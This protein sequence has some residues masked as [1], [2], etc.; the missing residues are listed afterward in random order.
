MKPFELLF[1]PYDK[2]PE[3]LQGMVTYRPAGTGTSQ[4]VM[5]FELRKDYQKFETTGCNG[6]LSERNYQTIVN[7]LKT[8]GDFYFE[9]R[10]F[11]LD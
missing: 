7:K 1:D 5:K 2:K 10:V 11:W 6:N 4:V 8:I 9:T 3:I